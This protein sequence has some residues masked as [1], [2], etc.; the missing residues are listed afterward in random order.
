MKT[1]SKEF[2][3]KPK[4]GVGKIGLLLTIILF[5]IFWFVFNRIASA[6]CGGLIES[7]PCGLFFLVLYFLACLGMGM[8]ISYF[9]LRVLKK[10][11]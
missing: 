2:L 1:G 10:N 5:I 6:Q 4:I 7:L 9:L 3:A 8:L 11:K